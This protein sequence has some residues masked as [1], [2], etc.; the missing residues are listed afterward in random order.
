[1]E[2]TVF[3]GFLRGKKEVLEKEYA[4]SARE[5]LGRGESSLKVNNLF[6]CRDFA[7]FA[8][9]RA[10]KGLFVMH[11]LQ[12]P[13]ETDLMELFVGAKELQPWLTRYEGFL[14]E[15]NSYCSKN[16]GDGENAKS[17]TILKSAFRFVEELVRIYS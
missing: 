15:L 11:D 9:V 10:M 5:F 14:S 7:R 2:E 4:Q 6:R 12:P 17:A 3:K 13:R 1:M 16:S 8:A